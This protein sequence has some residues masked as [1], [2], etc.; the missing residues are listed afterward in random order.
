M[1]RLERLTAGAPAFPLLV[2]FGLNCVDELDRA[3]F[4][5]LL[6]E[7][8][9][10][11]GLDLAGALLLVTLT[12]PLA[13]LLGLPI[14]HYADRASR[15]RL[16]RIGAGAWGVFA[17]TTGLAINTAT[18]V[19]SRTFSGLGKTV[20]DPTHNSLLADLYP[21]ETRAGI[22]SFYRAANNVG[23]FLGPVLAGALAF[24]FTWR[25]P[26]LVFAIP[27]FVLVVVAGRLREPV[28]GVMDRRA[29]GVTG[30]EAEQEETPASFGE[31]WRVVNSIRSLRRI[32][33][34]L[35]FLAAAVFGLPAILAL[36]YQDVYRVDEIQR[37]FLFAFNELFAVAGLLVGA[38]IAQRLLD[39]DPGRVVRFL[40]ITAV[41]IGGSMVLLAVSPN[42]GF[43]IAAHY[44]YGAISAIL[45]PGIY[46]VFSL[47]IP[48]RC[49]S[50]GFVS[51]TL[52]F[53]PGL[54]AL[55]IIGGIGDTYGLRTAIAVLAP[56]YLVGAVLMASAGPFL[57]ADIQHARS[58]SMAEHEVRRAMSTG[59]PRVLMVRNLD[60]AYDSVQVLFGVD[61]DLMEG[62]I[63][64]LL[65]TNGAGK[66][67]LLKAVSGLVDPA[68]GSIFYDG[69]DIT[70]ADAVHTARLGIIQVPGGKAVF[71][72]LT[73][74]EHLDLAA[75]WLIEDDDEHV[76]TTTAQVLE[77]FPRLAERRDQL[78]GSLSGGEQQ[79]L[80][81]G[82]AF[83]AKPR[84]LM[85][86]ELS[87]GLA[88]QIVEQL[89]G[90]VRRIN[91]AGTAVI[92]VEQS[93]NVALSLAQRAY[94]MEKG[95]VR[96]SGPTAELLERGDILRAVF[97][98]G[99]AAMSPAPRV[100]ARTPEPTEHREEVMAVDDLSVSFGGI[101]AVSDV[102]FTLG[103][104]EILGLIGPNGAGKT[105]V[106]DL[107]SG[108]LAPESGWIRFQGED[109]TGWS[110]DR[111]SRAGL[112]RS[113][114]DARIFPSLTVAENIA[115]ALERHLDVRDH[116]ADAVSLPDVARQE[117]DIEFT[118]GQLIELMGLGAFR[119]KFVS[120]LSTGSRRIVDLGMAIAYDPTVLILDEPSSGIA[121]RETEALGPLLLRIRDELGCAMLVIEHDMPL[122]TSISDR[123]LALELGAVIAEG[124]PEDVIADDRVVSSYLGGSMATIHRSG[125]MPPAAP[126]RRKGRLAANGRKP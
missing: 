62:E 91:D 94:F 104:R 31:A 24:W 71:P 4:S 69:L 121:Q 36:F 111:R 113:F 109:V 19:L 55:P 97:L 1:K 87:L 67:T 63:V 9:D 60:V 89:L 28:R 2:L 61:F 78:A 20:N 44:A 40:A 43:A 59:E 116:L 48:A 83:I 33:L 108:F 76:A 96:F 37:G 93:V 45:V 119:D 18:L 118:V 114:Q 54:L 106:F 117:R 46:A 15:V 51:G 38:P 98:Q 70:H 12:V 42:L 17:A 95:Q 8:R 125:T 88:P 92:L 122:I 49:R 56:I 86:D 99:A 112:G 32:Y 22:Y 105:T 65:G 7:I 5:I 6:P 120:E 25:M 82:M 123:M 11:M 115:V 10:S 52:W 66:S 41:G 14:A 101:K 81:L 29:L 39:R 80:A 75:S 64:A 110:P 47:A 26:F 74:D 21:I 68:A 126:A 85:I 50:L 72:T 16:A 13:V 73:V 35:P 84:L 27:T 79:M 77:M 30:E 102:S 107:I 3:A 124:A 34:G 90:I 103:G 57:N 100:S 53:L 23:L 58:A